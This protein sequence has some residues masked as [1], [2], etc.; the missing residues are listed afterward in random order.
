M[1]RPHSARG[2]WWYAIF[3]L[4]ATLVVA[5]DQ[6]SK[7]WI[8][9]D[10]L[11]GESL[12]EVGLFRIAHTTNTGAAFGL[13]RGQAPALTVVSVVGIVV[14]L[15]GTLFVYRRSSHFNSRLGTVALGLVLGGTAGNLIDRASLGYVTDFIGIGIWPDFN[16]ADSAV[17]VGTIMFA[18]YLLFPWQK[19]SPREN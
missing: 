5:A 6:L 8:R 2:R 14:I 19:A 17:V 7:L 10:L 9:S 12:V 15:L 4:T 3:F 13:F 18:Y 1:R 16:V 11:V